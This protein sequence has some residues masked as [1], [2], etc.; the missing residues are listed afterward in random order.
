M[1]SSEARAEI[2]GS[3]RPAP[4]GGRRVGPADP[5]ETVVVTVVLRRDPGSRA[6]PIREFL[7]PRPRDRPRYL[8][9]AE[10]AGTYGASAEDVGVVRSFAQSTGLDVVDEDR[11]RRT[12]RLSGSVAR[13]SAAFDVSLDRYEHPAGT[14]RARAGPLRVPVGLRERL[15]AVLGL[16]N[17]PQARTH[18]RICPANVPG[19]VAYTPPQVAAAYSFPS[20]ADGSGECVGLIELG[21]GY[22][23]ADL[24]QYFTSV[25]VAAPSVVAVS[26]DGATNSPTG[27]ASGPDGEVE[28]DVEVVGSI[29][30]GATVAVYF[31][32]NTDQG[33]VDAVSTAVHDPT[34]R[35]SVVSIS[36][37][38]PEG[39][40]T[41]QSRAALES[42]L[43]DA[44]AL[45]VTVL[46]AAGDDG[47]DD[48]GPGTGLSVDFPASSPEVIACGGTRLVLAGGAITE[49]V[50]WN[51]LAS[52]DG[53]TGG[54]VSVDFALPTY[55]A[56][57]GVPAAPNGFVGRGVPDVAG[58]ADPTTG[59]R[60][61][62]DGSSTVIG[63]TSAVAPL[64][65]ALIARINQV[66]GGP[67]GF[68]NARLY[69]A[70]GSGGFRDI[71]SGGNGGYQAGPGWD[72]CT[73][74][75]SPEGTA[76]AT[77]L[78]GD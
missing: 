68:V 6:P 53:A 4:E 55:Q 78:R 27:S 31:A 60:V 26:V 1:E 70:S 22:R 16:D 54:G 39:S 2:P 28:L 35:P 75:G 42:V 19:A 13:L 52:G 10:F 11:G 21:G 14:F 76:L 3:E 49:E 30:P 69:A 24:A 59:Y 34:Q 47:A 63:G 20:G 7:A 48:G 67:V 40:W 38:G 15:V 65:A 44:A 37:G 9:R 74:L 77:A 46:V 64:W 25:G 50:V 29:A 32:P 58:D 71:T 12:V 57:V 36:W 5:N 18:F 17:R 61:L 45:G 23:T 43:E 51:D 62:V 41:A 56:G 72:A 73:G 8:R 33:F 66:L